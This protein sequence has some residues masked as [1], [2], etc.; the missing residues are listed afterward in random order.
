MMR[1]LNHRKMVEN[2]VSDMVSGE[3]FSYEMRAGD[4][5]IGVI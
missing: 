4:S 5:W 1:R 3:V 2:L